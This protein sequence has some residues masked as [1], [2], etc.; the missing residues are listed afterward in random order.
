VRLPILDHREER[1]SRDGD[2]D[3]A[4][5]P[6]S[7]GRQAKATFAVFPVRIALHRGR[8]RVGANA[9][10]RLL[11]VGVGLELDWTTGS[12]AATADDDRD[13]AGAVIGA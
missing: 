12:I 13:V 7:A 9:A 6:W 4:Q 11:D 2:R 8:E 5:P 3:L 1:L 10:A